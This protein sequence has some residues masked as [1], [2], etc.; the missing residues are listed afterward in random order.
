MPQ[1]F[2]DYWVEKA[3]KTPLMILGLQDHAALLDGAALTAWPLANLALFV[4]FTLDE[5][6]TIKRIL[7]ITY[8]TAGAVDVGIYNAD[9]A[10]LVSSGSTAVTN[11]ILCRNFDIADTLLEAGRYYLAMASDATTFQ[12]VRA[13]PFSTGSN[14]QLGVRE[15]TAAFPLPASATFADNT[16]RAYIPVIGATLQP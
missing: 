12:A 9:G 3:V 7:A 5:A 13:A 11:V 10:R 6:V 8:S 14:M 1:G 4:P 15:Q 2:P 16:T